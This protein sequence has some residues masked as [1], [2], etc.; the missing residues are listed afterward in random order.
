M[1]IYIYIYG[2][3]LSNGATNDRYL[4]DA[5]VT[6]RTR[7]LPG[8]LRRKISGFGP[9][10]DGADSAEANCACNSS[11]GTFFCDFCWVTDIGV[12][13]KRCIWTIGLRP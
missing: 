7:P 6:Y 9:S 10:P 2:G 8:K 4:P 12:R 13:L 3:T 5:T 1:N 11:V